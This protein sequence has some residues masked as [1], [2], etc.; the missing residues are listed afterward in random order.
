[1]THPLFNFVFECVSFMIQLKLQMCKWHNEWIIIGSWGNGW[2]LTR[3]K[4]WPDSRVFSTLLTCSI[5]FYFVLLNFKGICLTQVKH[6][7]VVGYYPTTWV[8][9]TLITLFSEMLKIS[10]LVLVLQL[11]L[12]L[13]GFVVLNELHDSNCC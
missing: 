4:C 8:G 2:I 9:L 10:V 13:H 6:L 3:L 1:V 11:R 7:K 12:H 5:L